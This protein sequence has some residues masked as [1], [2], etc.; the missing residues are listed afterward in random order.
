MYFQ[1]SGPQPN[2]VVKG[3]EFDC[4]SLIGHR[5]VFLSSWIWL[6]LPQLLQKKSPE[7]EFSSRCNLNMFAL[8]RMLCLNH[9]ESPE[10]F[11]DHKGIKIKFKALVIM[12]SL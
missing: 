11:I 2:R 7:Y 1:R 3:E 6:V 5:N 10:I 9:L 12:T 8:L 4:S